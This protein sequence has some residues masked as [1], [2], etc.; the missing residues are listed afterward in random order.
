[1]KDLLNY[2]GLIYSIINKYPKDM[3]EDLYQAGM[4]GLVDAYKHYDPN[5]RSK[6]TTYAYYYIVGEVNKFIR[7]SSN[8]KLSKDLI[9]LKR[10][11]YK[12][13]DLMTQKLGRTPSNLEIALYLDI[14]VED[15]DLAINSD[16]GFV[17][18][19]SS[20]IKYD[21]IDN[22]DLM[23]EIDRLNRDERELIINRYFNDLTQ[24]EVSKIMG[25]SQVSVS[26]SE[27][28]VLRKLRNNL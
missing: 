8:L 24:S 4:L 1:M 26:R 7:E 16:V 28:K 10:S 18:I 9:K 27:E 23:L 17:D 3:R 13:Y 15:V 14:D 6:F 25:I 11:I 22:I 2:D 20:N 21:N 12:V 5:A 19:D